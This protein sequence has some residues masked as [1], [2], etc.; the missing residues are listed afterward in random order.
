MTQKD[1]VIN[2][3]LHNSVSISVDVHTH[4]D[5]V[6]RGQRATHFFLTAPPHKIKQRDDIKFKALTVKIRR[7]F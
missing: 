4:I 6:Q 1:P 2:T 5:D 7:R 3:Q